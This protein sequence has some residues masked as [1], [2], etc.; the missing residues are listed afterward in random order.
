MYGAKLESQ[1]N[2]TNNAALCKVTTTLFL[3]HSAS[4][5]AAATQAL[6]LCDAA[7]LQRTHT[8]PACSNTRPIRGRTCRLQANA[9]VTVHTPSPPELPR[10]RMALQRARLRC[11]CVALMAASSGMPFMLRSHVASRNS[12]ARTQMHTHVRGPG[13]RTCRHAR[14]TERHQKSISSHRSAT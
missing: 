7:R 6:R 12:C 8:R 13:S 1:Q 5:S 3:R 11:G 14:F 9:S 4:L 2:S 10:R